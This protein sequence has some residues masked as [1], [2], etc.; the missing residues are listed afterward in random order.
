M[1]ERMSG[2]IEWNVGRRASALRHNGAGII[3]GAILS[4][5]SDLS[6]FESPF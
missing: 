2:V 3:M 4:Y 6:D 1:I 5:L